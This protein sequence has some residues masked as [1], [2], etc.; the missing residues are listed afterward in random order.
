VVLVNGQTGCDQDS[1][2]DGCDREDVLPVP[3]E[4]LN[5]SYH[6]APCGSNL[7]NSRAPVVR[8]DLE[9]RIQVEEQVL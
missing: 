2:T 7:P 8:H 3:V 1:S 6:V 9:L 4:Q 5:V